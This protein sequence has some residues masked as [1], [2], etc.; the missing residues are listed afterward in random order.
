MENEITSPRAG[1]RL[2]A[3]RRAGPAGLDGPGHLPG[4][5]GRRL[6]EPRSRSARISRART[7]SRSARPPAEST[8]GSWSSTAASG[9]ET[10]SPEAAS[11]TRSSSTCATRCARCRTAGSCSS[12]APTAGGGPSYSRSRP[13]VEAGPDQASR[14]PSSR[15]TRTSAGSTSSPAQPVDH[16]LFLVCTHGKHDPCCARLRA[17][18]LR[19]A[20]RRARRPTGSGRSR[21]SAATASRATSSACP[22]AST[23][24]ASTAR[25]PGPVL[26]E[27]SRPADPD[28]RLPRALD[29]HVRRP[30]GRARGPRADRA[31]RHR[32]PH[33]RAGRS[34]RTRST[35]RHL[36]RRRRRHTSCGSTRSAGD[37][38]QLTCSSEI[39][40]AAAALRRQSSLI[41]SRPSRTRRR[42][43][44]SRLSSSSRPGRSAA[45]N[46]PSAS[47][48]ELELGG[49]PR[50]EAGARALRRRAAP[51]GRRRRG[52]R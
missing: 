26:D 44:T 43:S 17:P 35:R 50:R 16:P 20:P 32:R 47:Q 40:R 22:R 14:E 42:T 28:A 9:P 24:A 51:R 27:H 23:T 34:A 6:T 38:T 52:R 39:A 31:G 3:L 29:L 21:T 33:A 45:V 18:A 13:R 2:R 8:T 49:D 4:H 12:G 5:P 25:R 48:H 46:A 15:P 37:L 11:P 36:C 30:G 19:G 1:H 7:T 41:R 10:R